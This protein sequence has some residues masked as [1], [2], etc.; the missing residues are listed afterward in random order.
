MSKRSGEFSPRSRIP[1]ETQAR[2]GAGRR[3]GPKLLSGR[4]PSQSP[5]RS[6]ALWSRPSQRGTHFSHFGVAHGDDFDTQG[7]ARL[8]PLRYVGLHCSGSLGA[9]R[10][11]LSLF[12]TLARPSGFLV[13]W[14]NCCSRHHPGS[15]ARHPCL[16]LAAGAGDWERREQGEGGESLAMLERGSVTSSPGSG[17]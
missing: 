8:L 15:A 3:L 2:S 11:G 13:Q 7:L 9:T 16:C 5:R 1:Q 4:L 14:R 17:D 6:A 12:T 10:F